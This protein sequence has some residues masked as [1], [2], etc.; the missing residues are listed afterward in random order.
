MLW[1]L[2]AAL[3]VDAASLGALDAI[4]PPS[5]A[6]V[7]KKT[8][9]VVVNI[10]TSSQRAG[11]SA[12]ADPMEEFFNRFFGEAPPRENNQRSWGREF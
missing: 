10:S 1:I 5:F 3:R 2:G 9:P 12:S 11:R 7:A 6:A 4:R 8:M